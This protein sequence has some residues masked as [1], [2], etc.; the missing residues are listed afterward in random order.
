MQN[1]IKT[2]EPLRS[3]VRE[4]RLLGFEP[5]RRLDDRKVPATEAQQKVAEKGKTLKQKLEQLREFERQNRKKDSLK[6]IKEL[7]TAVEKQYGIELSDQQMEDMIHDLI[8]KHDKEVGTAIKIGAVETKTDEW[9]REETVGEASYMLVHASESAAKLVLQH[10]N[11]DPAK[12]DPETIRRIFKK[13]GFEV[14]EQEVDNPSEQ[15]DAYYRTKLYS[16]DKIPTARPFSKVVEEGWEV[17]VPVKGA[18]LKKAPVRPRI[19]PAPATEALLKENSAYKKYAKL[20]DK[21][22]GASESAGEAASDQVKIKSWPQFLREFKKVGRKVEGIQKVIRRGKDITEKVRSSLAGKGNADVRV[23]DIITFGGSAEKPTE[24]TAHKFFRNPSEANRRNFSSAEFAEKVRASKLTKAQKTEL[25]EAA[26][27]LDVTVTNRRVRES[28]KGRG[29]FLERQAAQ[30][31]NGGKEVQKLFAQR[32]GAQLELKDFYK[33]TPEKAVANKGKIK[34]ILGGESSVFMLR[35]DRMK[36]GG[37]FDSRIEETRGAAWLEDVEAPQK[38]RSTKEYAYKYA[39]I[40]DPKQKAEILKKYLAGREANPNNY[41]IAQVEIPNCENPA[42]VIKKIEAP[43]VAEA[44]KKKVR[45]SLTAV[46]YFRNTPGGWTLLFRIPD[47]FKPDSEFNYLADPAILDAAGE[48]LRES[49]YLR[50]RKR[51][52]PKPNKFIAERVDDVLGWWYGSFEG[53][54]KGEGKSRERTVVESLKNYLDG[55]DSIDSKDVPRDKA[56]SRIASDLERRLR[57]AGDGKSADSFFKRMQI[58]KVWQK[59]WLERGADERML[60]M[61]E[62]LRDWDCKNFDELAEKMTREEEAVYLAKIVKYNKDLAGKSWSEIGDEKVLELLG[63]YKVDKKLGALEAIRS[64]LYDEDKIN[65]ARPPLFIGDAVFVPPTFDKK[66]RQSKVVV[67]ENQSSITKEMINVHSPL[68]MFVQVASLAVGFVS[69]IRTG[70]GRADALGEYLEM[71][72]GSAEA[73][74]EFAKIFR[75]PKAFEAFRNFVIKG[76][77]PTKGG[78][79]I[80]L[81][82]NEISVLIPGWQLMTDILGCPGCGCTTE[83]GVVANPPS[84][85]PPA[86]GIPLE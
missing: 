43:V 52:D 79:K 78:N 48:T 74:E 69:Y 18:T 77:V 3:L 82:I 10:H 75:D 30:S 26:I 40:S 64:A 33:P 13:A 60:K 62:V 44:L 85:A 63:K 45:I 68:S 4:S 47:W 21:V 36:A 46:Q 27:K 53:R 19:I 81:P 84:G 15:E 49:E 2:F 61:A 12:A 67:W 66:E 51:L 37:K 9:G 17:E 24:S 23:G 6:A 71:A 73:K 72:E 41:Q 11:I 59:S 80:S 35:I 14:D 1:K 5:T 76:Q 25:I 20:L 32:I 22:Y 57:R 8:E 29:V 58:R 7:K 34:D 86:G 28:G 83:A 42:I 65:A 50:A 54:G 16:R 55:T 39:E 56:I 70:I 38:L 31:A